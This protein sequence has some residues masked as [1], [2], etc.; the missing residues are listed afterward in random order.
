MAD[1]TPDQQIDSAIALVTGA[2][3]MAG[4]RLL[5]EVLTEDSNNL[6]AH[7]EL[8][9]FSIQSGQYAKARERFKRVLEIDPTFAEAYPHLAQ[10][11]IIEE[12]TAEA[13]Q[14]FEQYKAAQPDSM[15]RREVQTY[16]DELKGTK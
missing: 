12:D 14:Y 16:I 13:I 8:G 15:V 10:V 3:P 4:I 1:L 5:R 7:F 9:K 6:R 11:A 2:N